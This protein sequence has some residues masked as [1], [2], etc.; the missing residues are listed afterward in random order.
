MFLEERLRLARPLRRS[1]NAVFPDRWSYFLGEIALYCFAVLVLTGTYL[2]FF[3][4]PSTVEQAYDGSYTPLRGVSVSRA[5]ASTMHISFDVRGGLFIRQVHHWAALLFMAVLVLHLCR[6]FFNGAFRK[7]RELTWLVGVVMFAVGLLEG[8][9]GYTLPDDL[10][11]GASLH[12]AASIMLSIPIVG[13]WLAFALFGGTYPPDILPRLFIVH[14]LIA[15]ALFAALIGTHLLLVIRQGH[16]HRPRISGLVLGLRAF[17][18]RVMRSLGL[19]ALVGG[20]LAAMG[21]LAQINPVWLY[22]PYKP[23]AVSAESHPDWYMFFLEGALRL[24]PPWEIRAGGYSVPALFWPGVVLPTVM[25]LIIASYP[26]VEARFSRDRASH[27]VAQRP[28]DAP[29]R[30]AAGAAGL[31]FYTVLSLGA[32]DDVAAKEF[33]VQI[34]RFVW[35]GRI[36][37]VLLPL[38][39]FVITHRTCRRLQRR[40]DERRRFGATTGVVERTPEGDWVEFRS[41]EASVPADQRT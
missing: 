37:A 1:L 15:P 4:D 38:I 28:R 2:S 26:W 35:A 30:T 34:E 10:L 23:S 29:V 41:C 27:Q 13:T 19:F 8:F 9:S 24:F 5:Y 6:T 25:F 39:A 14:V 31:A 32:A 20:L 18:G 33:D 36:G 17:P 22:G 7:P 21:G 12:I 40:D 11:S 16:T 3:Y